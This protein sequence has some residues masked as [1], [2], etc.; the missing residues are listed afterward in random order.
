MSSPS[1]FRLW[2]YVGHS[3]MPEHVLALGAEFDGEQVAIIEFRRALRSL[4]VW[5]LTTLELHR[6]PW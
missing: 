4:R 1:V 3:V 6:M 5:A 2:G